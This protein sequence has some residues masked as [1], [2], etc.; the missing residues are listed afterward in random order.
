MDAADEF[1]AICLKHP[2]TDKVRSHHYEFMYSHVLGNVRKTPGLRLLEIGIADGDSLRV[3]Q[4]YLNRPVLFG[5]DIL[6]SGMQ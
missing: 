1:V 3:W 6:E 5:I 4:E 2:K